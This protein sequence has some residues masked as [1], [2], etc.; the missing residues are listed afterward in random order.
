MTVENT[1]QASG[2]RAT[3]PRRRRSRRLALLFAAAALAIAVPLGAFAFGGGFHR[4]FHHGEVTPEA[5]LEHLTRMSGRMLDKV[6]ATEEQRVQIQ[7]V[8][9]EIAPQVAE[10]V[11]RGRATREAYREAFRAEVVDATALDRNKA[12]AVALAD[13]ALTLLNDTMVRVSNVLS[14]EQRM[15]LH[16]IMD[17]FRR[18]HRRGHHDRA[19]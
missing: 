11:K 6:D 4:A 8:V 5:A 7:A 18:G 14:V 3:K 9:N 10:L 2:P 15:E 16:E 17:K 19:E 12:D 1:E 13:D